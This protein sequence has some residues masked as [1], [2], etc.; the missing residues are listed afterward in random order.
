MVK[1][2]CEIW[3]ELQ[4]EFAVYQQATPGLRYF[5]LPDDRV[6]S[7]Q[8]KLHQLCRD[9][10]LPELFG[11]EDSSLLD[12]CDDPLFGSSWRRFRPFQA[13]G[14]RIGR[15]QDECVQLAI[16]RQ[17]ICA[18]WIGDPPNS[19]VNDTVSLH[20]YLREQCRQIFLCSSESML[21]DDAAVGTVDRVLQ[22][23]RHTSDWLF[24]MG[25][26]T[27]EPIEI[28]NPTSLADAK[29]M[30]FRL[31]NW[32]G[33][34]S[35]NSLVPSEA[36]TNRPT[37]LHFEC[38]E[39][40]RSHTYGPVTAKYDELGFALRREI[41]PAVGKT[42]LRKHF[43]K[44]AGTIRPL[45]W[46]RETVGLDSVDVYFV[47]ATLKDSVEARLK[48]YRALIAAKPNETQRNSTK[49]ASKKTRAKK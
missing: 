28:R 15:F 3:W 47:T 30:V 21:P 13:A 26:L 29:E 6:G 38:E 36:T 32:I 4:K 22:N 46:V 35:P 25:I 10:Q 11:P 49:S 24:A 19:P 41:D 48:E 31:L 39:P 43:A 2:F 40:P 9:L 5:L 33:R 23:V 42:Q 17:E 18:K 20:R 8:S 12:R 44:K 27:E 34:M 16:D 14:L 7:A 45:F 1:S 37:W